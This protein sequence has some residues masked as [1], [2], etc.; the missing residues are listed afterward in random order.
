MTEDKIWQT[1]QNAKVGD[2][3][4]CHYLA[5]QS[6]RRKW[7][8][9][10]TIIFS[11]SG[12]LGWKLWTESVFAPI[13]FGMI[14]IMQLVL[15][16]ETHFI[17]SEAQLTQISELRQVYIS[18]F[19]NLDRLFDHL[20]ASRITD[21]IACDQFFNIQEQMKKAESLDDKLQVVPYGRLA[22]KSQEEAKIFLTNYYNLKSD[23]KETFT[24]S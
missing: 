6:N 14:L 10:F 11:A 9:V 16:L 13:A 22:K 3:Y 21:E 8:Q 17:R 7:F 4:L 1:L 24:N 19:N 15:K 23:V 12:I 2:I 5:R 18:Y 20:S